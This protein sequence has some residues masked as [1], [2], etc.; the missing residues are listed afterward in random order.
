MKKTGAA[1]KRT[2]FKMRIKLFKREIKKSHIITA[3]LAVLLILSAV[4]LLVESKDTSQSTSAII[5]GVSFSGDYK[6]E[7]GEWRPIIAGE[8]IS[9]TSGTVYLKGVFMMHDPSTGEAMFPVSAGTTVYLYFNHIGGSVELSS[10]YK[11]PFDAENSQFGEDACAIMTGYFTTEDTSEVTITLNNPHAF[12]NENAIDVFLE[13]MSIAPGVYFENGMLEKG[14]AERNVGL[15]IVISSLI[16]L[17]IAVFSAV[18][19]LQYTKELWLIGLMSI[20][21]GGYMLFDAFGVNVWNE[22]YVFNTRALGLCMMLYMFFSSALVATLLKGRSKI[23]SFYATLASGTVTAVCILISLLDTVTF[24]DTF[25]YWAIFESAVCI[26]LL[27]CQ[28]AGIRESSTN[29]KLLNAVIAVPLLAFSIDFLATGLGWWEGGLISKH[30]YIAIF[31]IVLVIVLRIIPSHINAA[32]TARQLEAE[33]QALKLELQ[34]SRISIMLS[35]MQPHF[36]FNTLNTIYHLCEINPD[37]ARKTIS[38][39]SEYLRNNIDT[40]GQSEMISFEKE[41]S[42]VKTY[43]N[44]EKVRFDDELEITYDIASTDFKLPVLTVQPIVENAVKHGTSKKRGVSTLLIMTREHA[45]RYEIIIK[46][47]GVGFDP[48]SYQNDGHKHVGIDSVRERL[49]N[50]CGGSLSISSE[51]GSGTEATIVIP[52]R[53]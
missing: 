46:D 20:S 22:S 25:L 50:L 32:L 47:S 15:L 37:T 14:A 21:A 49:T 8:H 52:K 18:I 11:I 13:N 30:V 3:A 19:Q 23:I 44:I 43:L 5:A 9:A 39:F 36:I 41:L 7:D 53:D 45:D 51:K 29:G 28:V 27:A 1:L 2:G 26:L 16:I 34:E 42:F 4:F 40:L 38:Y 35:Q 33:R 12:G 48:E 24:Y 17:G 10:G 6:I 31:L